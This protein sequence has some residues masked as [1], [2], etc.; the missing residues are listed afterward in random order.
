[1]IISTTNIKLEMARSEV[2]QNLIVLIRRDPGY[3]ASGDLK[4]ISVIMWPSPSHGN[5]ENGIRIAA[6]SWSFSEA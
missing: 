5:E 6:V 1:M 4:R 2:C 3:G